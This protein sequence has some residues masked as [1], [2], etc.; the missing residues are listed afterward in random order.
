MKNF[1]KLLAFT[2]VLAIS[3]CACL[4]LSLAETS[5]LEAADKLL[6]KITITFDKSSYE[7]GKPVTASYT[8]SGG[9]GTY[10][11]MSY[12]A[13]SVD[14][15]TSQYI[16]GSELKEASGTITFTPEF[17]QEA[18]IY[19]EAEDSEHRRFM[20]ESDHVA[21]T[22]APVV[23]PVIA[24]IT[25]D[26]DT[27]EVGTPV[28]ASYEVTGGSGKYN[29]IYESYYM[30]GG[31]GTT[32]VYGETQEAK[33]T[34]TFTPTKQQVIIAYISGEDTE[35]R[36]FYADIGLTSEG[37]GSESSNLTVTV[38]F[39][40]KSYPLGKPI[41]ANYTI[42]GG[43]GSYTDISF[44]CTSY[45]GPDCIYIDQ[46]Q[47]TAASGTITFTPKYGQFASVTVFVTD[48]A[49]SYVDSSES[50]IL[51]DKS[52]KKPTLSKVTATS[53]KKIKVEWQ[54]LSKKE[55]K[56]V[57]Y[58]EVYVSTDKNFETIVGYKQVSPKKSS[59]TIK[60]LQKNTKYYVRIRTIGE[61]EEGV[62]IFSPWSSVKK[63]KT[64]KK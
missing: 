23:E 55:I 14:N 42:T 27:C 17:G 20:Y 36:G 8:I 22:G 6:G 37:S 56:K 39:G 41:T 10:T 25:L 29:I 26:K 54:K 1:R 38:T 5:S 49:S 9:S 34:F 44:A 24:K 47:L 28:T 16:D 52:L 21:L 35:G 30:D 46:G 31:P 63:V 43:T 64:K 40:K 60:D 58:I 61:N 59:V 12:A 53:K 62:M 11:Y 45:D 18:Y 50:V 32:L 13:F 19:I 15:G 7:V 57:K 3:L 4:P 48:S 51:T 33:G 2:L